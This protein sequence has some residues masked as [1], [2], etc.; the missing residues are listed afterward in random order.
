MN[1]VRYFPAIT[2]PVPKERIYK[3][4]G[5]RR[6]RT[7][8]DAASRLEI[9]RVID[10]AVSMIQLRGVARK[11]AIVGNDGTRTELGSGHTITSA[12]LAA[13]LSG[14]EE[15]LLMGATAGRDVITAID[16][17]T[18]R[19]A[20]TRAVVYDAAAS[21]MVDDAL[22]WLCTYFNRELSRECRL[23]TKRRFSAGY[24][25]FALEEQRYIHAFLHMDKL[26]VH[27]NENH[28]LIPEKSVTAVTGVW[29]K[30]GGSE[31]K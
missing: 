24:G 30:E 19:G 20:M 28:I 11:T 15:A 10:D 21:E 6:D 14:A 18:G 31:K 22:D 3:R 2:V 13:F 17:E 23:V 16:E 4:L 1:E 12:K 27:I 8:L 25:D 9:D 5:F 26:D 29:L 7:K